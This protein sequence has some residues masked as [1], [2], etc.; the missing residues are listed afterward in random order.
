M[1]Y[2]CFMINV[3]FRSLLVICLV[4]G[5]INWPNNAMAQEWDPTFVQPHT[6]GQFDLTLKGANHFAALAL[7]CIEQEYP[8]KPGHVVHNAE[9]VQNPRTLHP[10][11]YGCF[12][13]HSAVHGHW[14]L[15]RLLKLYPDMDQAA[16]IR[17]A[18]ARNITPAT[19]AVETAYF[20]EPG[21]KSFERTYGWGWLLT[22]QS[23]LLTWDDSLGN[24][25]ALT[26]QPLAD[27]IANLYIDF[28]PRQT[29]PNRTGEHPNTAFGL[30]L[31]WDYAKINRTDSLQNATLA[32][33]DRYF[34]SDRACPGHYEPGGSD[35]L[36]PCLEEADLMR[37][38]LAP[39]EFVEWYNAFFPEIPSS[40]LTPATVSDRTDGKLVHLDGL[41]LSRIWCMK[42]LIS[43]L[44]E[45]HPHRD[46][47]EKMASE[48]LTVT[49]P[50]IASGNYEGE[51]WLASF[52]VYAL[53]MNP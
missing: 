15:V 9:E 31:A 17:A 10:A 43:A 52:A 41:N 53:T 33:A 26:L 42:G 19:I 48:H 1:L 12:D 32:A 34:L 11:F 18:L 39:E 50:N 44:P 47:W 27:V 23:E 28:L 13:W 36:S 14:M 20:Q 2:V 46:T 45:T 51:H 40:Y 5:M 49:L 16:D 3:L 24:A 37:R 6:D 30:R 7:H 4:I 35:F 22:L 8:N 25:L 21:R 29:Y 38:L